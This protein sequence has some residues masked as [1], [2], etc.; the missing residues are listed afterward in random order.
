M[1]YERHKHENNL[2]THFKA[3]AK[4]IDSDTEVEFCS[5]KWSVY[6]TLKKNVHGRFCIC[7]F[8]GNWTCEQMSHLL[9]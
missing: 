7:R 2:L 5:F 6:K 9:P 1:R 8:R 3:D 4:A